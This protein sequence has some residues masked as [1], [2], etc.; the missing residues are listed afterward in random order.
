M[1][2]SIVIG[3][4]VLVLLILAVKYMTGRSKPSDQRGSLES[5]ACSIATIFRRNTNEVARSIRTPQV[6]K[7]EAM[8]EV[9]DAIQNLEQ[10]YKSSKV[11]LKLTLKNLEEKLLPKLKDDPGRMEQKARAA[12][13][14]W[15]E[16]K[17]S[18][19]GEIA[20]FKENAI[21]FLDMKKKA[22]D[23][24]TQV[25]KTITKIKVALDTSE[26]QYDMDRTELQMIKADLECVVSV[27]QIQLQESINKIKSIQDELTSRVD[28]DNIRAEVDAEL[29][30]EST[31]VT[32]DYESEFENL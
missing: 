1:I 22:I 4:L 30:N 23:R 25:E 17:A 6:M 32:T 26:A 9:D 7:D 19:G 29:R 18:E 5:I 15:E 8:Q 13:K 12:K 14:K 3:V 11:Q 28:E 21:K 10:S 16:S 31:V 2:T 20:K 24:I 27:P